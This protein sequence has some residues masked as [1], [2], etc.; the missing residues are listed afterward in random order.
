MS[1][2]GNPTNYRFAFAENEEVNPGD[3]LH[4]RRFHENG[5]RNIAFLR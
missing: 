5:E 2:R 3:P 1:C 4:M